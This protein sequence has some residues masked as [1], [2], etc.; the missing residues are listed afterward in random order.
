[1]DIKS[2]RNNNVLIIPLYQT[3]YLTKINFE[4]R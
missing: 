3:V 4:V 1:M 2:H